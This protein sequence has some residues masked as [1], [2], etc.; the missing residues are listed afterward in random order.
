M[1]PN[2]GVPLRSSR[3][4]A[5]GNRPSPAAASDTCAQTITQPLIAPKVD[6]AAST[7]M[8]SAAPGPQTRLA[9]SAIGAPDPFSTSVGTRPITTVQARMVAM[10]ASR[11]PSS[12]ARG[13]VRSGSRIEPAGTVAT[14]SPHSAHMVRITVVLATL[15]RLAPLGLNGT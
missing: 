8:A 7:A 14:S 10:P 2:A 11:V 3:A 5:R 12:V 6:T 4:K 9:A 15:G 1:I 13:M